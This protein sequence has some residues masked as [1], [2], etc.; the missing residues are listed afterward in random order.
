MTSVKICAIDDIAPNSGRA[1]LVE[2]KQIAVFRLVTAAGEEFFAIDNFCPFAGANVISR[3]IVGSLKGK[4][5][6]ASPIYKQHFD[7]ESG[8]CLEDETVSLRTW[9]LSLQGDRVYLDSQQM[10]AA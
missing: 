1:A 10:A 8:Q 9:K 3:G 2:G 5:V 6:V 7:L 4:K